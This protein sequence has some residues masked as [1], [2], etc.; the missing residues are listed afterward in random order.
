MTPVAPTSAERAL[1]VSKRD[2]ST[3]SFIPAIRGSY[4]FISGFWLP[5]AYKRQPSFGEAA[6]RTQSF[7]LLLAVFVF[8]FFS[9][10]G[11]K[12]A[13]LKPFPVSIQCWTYHKFTF[14][15]TLDKVKDLGVRHIQAYP[16]QTIDRAD[17]SAKFI[18]TMG[19]AEIRA[20]NDK[21]KAAGVS[22]A[23]YGVVDFKNDEADIRRVFDFAKKM[24]IGTVVCE[25]AFDDWTL[26]AKLA[27]EYSLNIAVHNHPLPSKYAKPD[28]V[29]EHIK[30]LDK[31]FG[32]CADNGH[33]TRAG[34]KTADALS[35]L[36]GR[37]LDIHLK[38]LD[39]ASPEAVDV[40]FG[41]GVSAVRDILAELARQKY[42][43]YITIEYEN[44]NEV[45]DPSPSVRKCVQFLKEAA[46]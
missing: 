37:I 6:M 21:L 40:P 20:V 11:A 17:E 36:R 32:A 1:P 41:Q 42:A 19:D 4:I 7:S 24:G 22:V 44:P 28:A 3:V 33:W 8:S 34:V 26:L 15:E 45:D 14:Y 18:H 13:K 23:A 30:G 9:T 25:P 29:Y 16:G 31:R 27:R 2:A 38:D 35:L 43:G 10:A 12:N 39:S 46:K 5:A